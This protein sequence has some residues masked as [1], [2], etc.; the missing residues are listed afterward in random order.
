M[1]EPQQQHQQ[2]QQQQL[3]TALPARDQLGAGQAHWPPA[4]Q[5]LQQLP[6]Q[7]PQQQ[8]QHQQP[9]QQQQQQQQSMALPSR[10]QLGPDQLRAL[11]KVMDGSCVF[12]TGS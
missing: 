2:Q 3:G 1:Q 9:Q 11:D 12:L 10:D 7:E 8:Q 5:L 4:L 6:M